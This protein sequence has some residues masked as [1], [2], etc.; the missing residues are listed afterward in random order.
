MPKIIN[1]SGKEVIKIFEKFGFKKV[2]QKGSHVKLVRISET[3]KE[4]L[5]IPLHKELDKGTL[6][7]IYKKSLQF[8]SEKEIR[9]YFYSE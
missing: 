4:I 3:Q 2:S 9:K 5:E 1:L 6:K 8:I 7:A